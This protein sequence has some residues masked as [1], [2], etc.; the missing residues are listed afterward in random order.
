LK[1][2]SASV[3]GL[4]NQLRRLSSVGSIHSLENRQKRPTREGGLKLL[5]H[6]LVLLLPWEASN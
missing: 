5:I 6:W 1:K 4:N 3:V 2:W